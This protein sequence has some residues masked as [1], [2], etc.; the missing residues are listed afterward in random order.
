MYECKPLA[1]F[2]LCICLL[3]WQPTVTFASCCHGIM[4]RNWLLA[5]P[6]HYIEDVAIAP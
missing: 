3:Y 5:L 2:F 1:S 4:C 6:A